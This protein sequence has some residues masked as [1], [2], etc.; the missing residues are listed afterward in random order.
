MGA[1]LSKTEI[2]QPSRTLL[3]VDCG[4]SITSWWFATDIPPISL[5]NLRGERSG[6]LPGL[7]INKDRNLLPGQ[8]HDAIDGRH[9]NKKVN[10]GFVGGNVG[11]VQV[12]EL[13]IET[14]TVTKVLY[15]LPSEKVRGK[16][17]SIATFISS[18]LICSRVIFE[19]ILYSSSSDDFLRN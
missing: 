8:D 18:S 6:Y 19:C 1:S 10:V 14:V 5:E 9:P 12:D 15:G 2:P 7:V 4:Y 16:L 3:V 17:F 13:F 11:P